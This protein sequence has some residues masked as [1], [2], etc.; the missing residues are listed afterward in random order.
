MSTGGGVPRYLRAVSTTMI[1]SH[2]V[3][4]TIIL[5]SGHQGRATPNSQGRSPPCALARLWLE[6]ERDRASSLLV[7]PVVRLLLPRHNSRIT[8]ERSAMTI[9]HAKASV[10]LSPTANGV[11][12]RSAITPTGSAATGSKPNPS[13]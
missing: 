4:A 1:G 13:E 7:E 6:R 11:L 2:R 9:A 5:C 3:P 12:T 10:A 8:V